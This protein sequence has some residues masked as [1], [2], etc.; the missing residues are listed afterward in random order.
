MQNGIRY[1]PGAYFS[2]DIRRHLR[3]QY[4]ALLFGETFF[5]I[6]EDGNPYW[7]TQIQRHRLFLLNPENIGVVLTDA[8][9]GQSQR[10]GLAEVPEWV[11]TVFDGD[12]VCEKYD[13]YGMLSGGFWNSIF[14]KK[15]CRISTKC[16]FED[17]DGR[18]MALIDYDIQPLDHL[19]LISVPIAG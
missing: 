16:E 10:F 3:M 11:D 5:E 7:I 8:V 14:G 15:G 4:P 1:T 17:E 18:E 6:D 12:Y 9:T 2:Q 19:H 13:N